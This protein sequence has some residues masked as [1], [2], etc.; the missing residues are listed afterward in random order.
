MLL[1][2]KSPSFYQIFTLPN[3][4]TA[5]GMN[6]RVLCYLNIY[7]ELVRANALREKVLTVSKSRDIKFA[8]QM[9]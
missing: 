4:P 1:Q 3:A 7:T 8:L 9:S 5:L 6:A 2:G